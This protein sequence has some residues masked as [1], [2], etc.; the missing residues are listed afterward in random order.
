MI[1]AAGEQGGALPLALETA[2]RRPHASKSIPIPSSSAARTR[3]DEKTERDRKDDEDQSSGAAEV[4]SEDSASSVPT[5]EEDEAEDEV[6]VEEKNLQATTTTPGEERKL[7]LTQSCPET[8]SKSAWFDDDEQEDCCCICLEAFDEKNP[9]K[10]TKCGHEYHLQ[11]IM[12][13]YQRNSCCPMC[14]TDVELVEEEAQ[15]LLACVERGL[16]RSPPESSGALGAGNGSNRRLG[17]MA[18]HH[19]SSLRG[20][21]P[22]PGNGDRRRTFS[23]TFPTREASSSSSSSATTSGTSRSRSG[24]GSLSLANFKKTTSGFFRKLRNRSSSSN[25]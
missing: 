11:C 19:R 9:A 16:S 14:G 6:K 25:Q 2:L 18:A 24:S 7:L 1:A 17:L 22:Y 21:I 5:G 3:S 10:L 15:S 23:V 20:D 8:A 12:Q 13:W 4:V